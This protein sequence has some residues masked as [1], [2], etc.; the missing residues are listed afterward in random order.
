MTEVKGDDPLLLALH[1]E[2]EI[3]IDI[4]KPIVKTLHGMQIY[5]WKGLIAVDDAVLEAGGIPKTLAQQLRSFRPQA[6]AGVPTDILKRVATLEVKVS[7][8]TEPALGLFN[9]VDG[10]GSKAFSDR[11]KKRVK[12]GPTV[13]ETGK[14]QYAWTPVCAICGI[15]DP[16][17]GLP[18]LSVAHILPGEPHELKKWQATATA[19]QTVNRPR[20]QTDYDFGPD[21]NAFTLCGNKT[22]ADSCHFAFD[23]HLV[24]V[25]YNPFSQKYDVVWFDETAAVTPEQKNARTLITPPWFNPFKRG[26]AFHTMESARRHARINDPAFIKT[27]MDSF[28]L[29]LRSEETEAGESEDSASNSESSGVQSMNTTTQSL[30]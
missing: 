11:Q 25:L 26:F 20:F 8:T 18:I 17:E 12:L 13:Q 9:G 27:I 15:T 14:S 23:N 30:G 24:G 29:S 6:L 19:F 5:S 2:L 16:P 1:K 3:P 21:R 4:L 22:K 28:A 10:C 7:M